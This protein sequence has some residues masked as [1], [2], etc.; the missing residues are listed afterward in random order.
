MDI[1]LELTKK[2]IAFNDGDP[3]RIQHFLKVHSFASL[4]GREEGLD[5]H[6]QFILETAALVHDIGIRPAELKYDGHCN[7]KLQEKEGPEPARKMLSSL[8]FEPDVIDRVCYLV[9]HHHT[10][11]NVDGADYQI[12]LEADFLVN[13]YEDGASMKAVQTARDSIFRT[14]AGTWILDT[15]FLSR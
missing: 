5:E 4:I 6:T 9:G 2:M 1:F 3:K 13:L 15:M 10:Y 7:G 14:K 11:E 8:G 12:L